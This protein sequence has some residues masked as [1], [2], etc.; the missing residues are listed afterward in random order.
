M[1]KL[2]YSAIMSL[3]GYIEDQ[4]GS[5]EWA[6]PSPEVHSYVND[7]QHNIGTHIY[8]RRMY[9]TM[10]VWQTLG[11]DP[12]I[13]GPEA[14]YAA[15]WIALDKIVYSQSLENVWTSRTRLERD[16]DPRAIQQLKEGSELDISI[17][18][19]TLA[20][21]AFRAG[22]VDEL[23]LFLLPLLVGGGKTGLP[24]DIFPELELVDQRRFADGVVH[25][26]YN[27]H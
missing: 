9:Q 20:E 14:D 27:V 22:L 13:S 1:S 25:L 8:G 5:F 10:A 21:H 18:G 3:D 16:F 4:D 2:V 19:P 15:L 7:L 26:H 23:H 12:D 6:A 24:K 11:D 17:G